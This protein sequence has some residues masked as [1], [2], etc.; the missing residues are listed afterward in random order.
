MSCANQLDHRPA[1]R[2]PGA[3][4]PSCRARSAA[5]S[6][7]SLV[8]SQPS[9]SQGPGNRKVGSGRTP[10][11]AWHHAMQEFPSDREHQR[12]DRGP[13]REGH[14]PHWWIGRVEAAAAARVRSGTQAPCERAPNPRP[15]LSRLRPERVPVPTAIVLLTLSSARAARHLLIR[16]HD[17]SLPTQRCCRAMWQAVRNEIIQPRQLSSGDLDKVEKLRRLL[18]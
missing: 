4:D 11:E 7:G 14:A 13:E 1:G 15:R 12:G 16:P 10:E 2:W 18:E 5:T 6:P 8:L 9:R 17:D 3:I